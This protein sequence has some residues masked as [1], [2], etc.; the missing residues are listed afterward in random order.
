MK[1]IDLN[2]LFNFR[3]KVVIITGSEGKLGSK[4]SDLYINLGSKVYGIDLKSKNKIDDK[5]F[6]RGSITNE[7]FLKNVLLKILNKEKRIDIIINNAAATVYTPFEKRTEKEINLVLN[8]N[9]KGTI[10]VCRTYFALHKKKKLKSCKIINIASIYGIV[11]PDF[12]IYGK[13]DNINSEIY[14]ASKAALI[15]LTKYFAVSMAKHNI[16]VNCISPGGIEDKKHSKS[17][18]K[19]YR[20]RVPLNRMA[21]VSDLYGALIYFSGENCN[22]TIGQNLIIDGG[23]SI[24]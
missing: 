19:N 4:I 5:K 22:Y 9:I 23:L 21:N 17:F 12:R 11:S 16:K 1:K 14:G 10:N 15:Q 3:N 18:I 24:W 8:T 2:K 13:K 6:F 7:K 20:S